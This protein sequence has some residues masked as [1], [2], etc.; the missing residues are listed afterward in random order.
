MLILEED[1]VQVSAVPAFAGVTDERPDR[2]AIFTITRTDVFLETWLR[3]N[4]KHFTDCYVLF[5]Q[6]HINEHDRELC[7]RF[8]AIAIQIYRNSECSWTWISDTANK[9]ATF[10][11]NSYRAVA[12]TDID[13]III[14]PR[15]RLQDLD[16]LE[17]YVRFV[18]LEIIQDDIEMPLE[19]DKPVRGQRD[20][21]Y[22][23]TNVCKVVLKKRASY[24]WDVGQH[25]LI[26]EP[27]QLFYGMIKD[28][29]NL[30][31]EVYLVHLHYFDKSVALHRSRSRTNI[32]KFTEASELGKQAWTKNMQELNA[33][34]AKKQRESKP[35]ADRRCGSFVLR[36]DPY[37][38]IGQ[39]DLNPTILN[40]IRG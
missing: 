2:S 34:F 24:L 13:E 9:F 29:P 27:Y 12:Y 5:H 20:L 21:V 25:K 38:I 30:H 36:D 6:D 39:I 19:W 4:S 33:S 17:D 37:E 32:D 8:G 15:G 22:S 10:L 26:T 16:K 1:D 7:A 14:D 23:S 11:L 18:G 35:F 3:N 40:N 31:P 28:L